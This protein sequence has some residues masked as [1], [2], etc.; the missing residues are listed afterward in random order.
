LAFGGFLVLGQFMII[1]FLSPSIVANAGLRESQLPL[2]YLVGGTLTFIT[3]PLVGRLSDQI[4]KHRVFKYGLISSIF[5]TLWITHL[6]VQPVYLTLTIVGLFFIC[7]NA[8]WVPALA[9]ISSVPS[10]QYRGSFMSFVGCIQQL[11]AGLGAVIAGAI[12]T[13]DANGHLH[14]YGWVGV[15]AVIVSFT[16]LLL[17]YLVIR[18]RT[19]AN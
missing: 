17:S 13:R 11:M 9:L 5:V 19:Q 7:V 10:P 3:G 4:G 16:A 1:P 8:R 15:V 18:E 2:I 12:V 6:S 14:N